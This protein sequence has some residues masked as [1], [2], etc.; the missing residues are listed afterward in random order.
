MNPLNRSALHPAVIL[1]ALIACLLIYFFFGCSS[2]KAKHDYL[3]DARLLLG[4]SVELSEKSFKNNDASTMKILISQQE[5]I[6][7]EANDL[8]VPAGYVIGDTIKVRLLQSLQVDTS[9]NNA[10]LKPED[11]EQTKLN[12]N[13]KSLF[14]DL[15]SVTALYPKTQLD[16]LIIIER[17]K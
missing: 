5:K 6:I 14:N 4:R 1:F 15:L 12:P 2:N 7:K 8:K 13:E 9:I 17:A 10:L 3:D 16:S 11:P